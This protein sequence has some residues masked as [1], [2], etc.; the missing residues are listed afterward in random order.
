[1]GEKSVIDSLS[2]PRPLNKL[3]RESFLFAVPVCKKLV[4][5]L[6]N[7]KNRRKFKC[8]A[9]G[10]PLTFGSFAERTQIPLDA[11]AKG[12]LLPFGLL[13]CEIHELHA[14]QIMFCHTAERT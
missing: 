8:T 10:A 6:L 12:N 14:M 7:P 3:F 4:N 9:C 5:R 1:M 2:K 13:T 11:V